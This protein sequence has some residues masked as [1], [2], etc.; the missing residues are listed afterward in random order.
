MNHSHKFDGIQIDAD[1]IIQYKDLPH[2]SDGF[3]LVLNLQNWEVRKV[4]L[5]S[6][7]HTI[8]DRFFPFIPNLNLSEPWPL[9]K[10]RIEKH[11][12]QLLSAHGMPQVIVLLQEDLKSLFKPAL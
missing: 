2:I 8:H 5:Y 9:E 1:G 4:L 10:K 6:I 11:L 12:N 7:F 3:T